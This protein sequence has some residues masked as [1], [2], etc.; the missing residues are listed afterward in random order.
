MKP[1]DWPEALTR[2]ARPEPVARLGVDLD[3]NAHTAQVW[4]T[5]IRGLTPHPLQVWSKGAGTALSVWGVQHA[6]I[7]GMGSAPG[8]P[9]GWRR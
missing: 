5:S 3:A 1:T 9:W 6:H 7:K 2:L 8:R 4:N